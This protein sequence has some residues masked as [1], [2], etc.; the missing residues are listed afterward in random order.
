VTGN[1]WFEGHKVRHGT[2]SGW[3]LHQELG[4]DRPC[5]P[6]YR[7]KA[8]YDARRRSAPLETQRN[9]AHAAAQH[10]AHKRL[11]HMFPEL[12]KKFY[13]EEKRQVFAERDLP[14]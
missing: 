12:Y 13:D 4:H 8:A 1:D 9:R 2:A 11:V 14:L 5:D 10:R 6:C 3:R 7:A